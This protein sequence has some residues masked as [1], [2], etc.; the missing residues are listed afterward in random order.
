MTT[1][2]HHDLGPNVV[3]VRS[4]SRPAGAA[5]ETSLA[6]RGLGPRLSRRSLIAGLACALLLAGAVAPSM[7]QGTIYYYYRPNNGFPVSLRAVNADGSSDRLIFGNISTSP[8]DGRQ[9]HQA[10]P[11]CSHAS[12]NGAL[13]WLV[14]LNDDQYNGPGL[15]FGYGTLYQATAGPNGTT[16]MVR[17]S[18]FDINNQPHGGPRR[19]R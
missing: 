5:I 10:I 12:H 2:T 15:N 1:R 13:T 4:L 19:R 3:P 7:A 17:L 9:N 18:N 16:T 6:H 14:L 8:L 11:S